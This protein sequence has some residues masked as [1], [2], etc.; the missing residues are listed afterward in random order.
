MEF[1]LKNSQNRLG[2]HDSKIGLAYH[3]TNEQVNPYAKNKPCGG[4][5][6]NWG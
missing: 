5:L 3:R 2:T 1:V 6:D 4:Y